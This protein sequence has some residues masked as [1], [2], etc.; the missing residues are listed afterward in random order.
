MAASSD[1]NSKDTGTNNDTTTMDD[2]DVTVNTENPPTKPT[3]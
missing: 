1:K 3:L 2:D